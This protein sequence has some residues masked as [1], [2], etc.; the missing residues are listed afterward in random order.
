MILETVQEI[1][2][3]GDPDRFLSSRAAP[4]E[5]RPRL[6][7]LYAFNIEVS[8]APWVASEP[9]LA[10]MRL[11]WWADA[12]RQIESGDSVPRHDVCEALRDT[13]ASAS[14]PT[15]TLLQIID[16]RHADVSGLE[17]ELDAIGD[18]VSSTSASVTWLAALALGAPRECEIVAREFGW[19]AGM[20]SLFRAE[21]R[22]ASRGRSLFGGRPD[23]VQ[24]LAS[25]A[26]SKIASARS[27]RQD[28][29]SSALA[30][31]LAGWRADRALY[32][33]AKDPGKVERGELT[34]SE[35]RRRATLSWRSL[36]GNW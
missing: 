9:G 29:P 32:L 2:R 27:A 24:K 31:M 16:A 14:L 11:Q 35:F 34:E 10:A 28:V 17:P 23:L 20:A 13:V 21:P 30:A 33:A 12:V 26:L 22:L 5:L 19:G 4:L 3:R 8:R 7:S 18:Y 25:A 1:V 6:W 36:T 15:E